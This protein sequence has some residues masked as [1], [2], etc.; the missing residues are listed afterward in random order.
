MKS[1]GMITDE[2]CK[3]F[4]LLHLIK[5]RVKAVQELKAI[6]AQHE[7][8]DIRHGSGLPQPVL[9]DHVPV[10]VVGAYLL[11][12]VH[13]AHLSLAR[14][15]QPLLVGGELPLVEEAAQ[16]DKGAL[17]VLGLGPLLLTLH[18]NS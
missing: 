3:L 1:R 18:N 12:A 15:S 6:V 16:A 17:L 5:A 2:L 11:I 4:R 7:G 9:C 10:E 13:G 8:G 14:G